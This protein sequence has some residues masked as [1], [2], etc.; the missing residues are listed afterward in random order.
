MTETPIA[1]VSICESNIYDSSN[2]S[3]S[4]MDEK[5]DTAIQTYCNKMYKSNKQFIY[6][7]IDDI[8]RM[9]LPNEE[10][11][12]DFMRRFWID[13]GE[14]HSPVLRHLIPKAKLEQSEREKAVQRLED[15]KTLDHYSMDGFI[16]PALDDAQ[17]QVFIETFKTVANEVAETEKDG[18]PWI[19]ATDELKSFLKYACRLEDPN[20][21]FWDVW[22]FAPYDERDGDKTPAEL[23]ENFLEQLR[24]EH[25]CIV[26]DLVPN[27]E[28]KACFLWGETT[29]GNE[30]YWTIYA[31][32]PIHE[33]GFNCD[34]SKKDHQWAWRILLTGLSMYDSL[35]YT[36]FD[37]IL[38]FINWLGSWSERMDPKDLRQ[39]VFEDT[40]GRFPSQSAYAQLK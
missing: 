30:T 34:K 13:L 1:S 31:Y 6:D 25:S 12:L 38:D 29:R 2:L 7:I 4:S 23:R 36:T 24:D 3:L 26:D 39:Q 19:Q 16:P 17:R 40:Y 14:S 28:P 8:E 10:G 33:W 22:E 5:M 32:C 21:R 37:S 11:K 27:I 18:A 9:N 15:V 20:F 35:G